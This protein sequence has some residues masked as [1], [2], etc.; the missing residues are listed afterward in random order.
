MD[1]KSRDKLI[2]KTEAA[3]KE[4]LANGGKIEEVAPNRAPKPTTANGKNKGAKPLRDPTARWP[5]R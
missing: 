3:I 4:F 5:K 2:E 1:E